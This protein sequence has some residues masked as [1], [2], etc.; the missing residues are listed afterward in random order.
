M[1]SK[2]VLYSVVYYSF[3]FILFAALACNN[4]KPPPATDIANTPQELEIK[5]TDIIES[6]LGYAAGHDGRIDDSIRLV[7]THLLQSIY[8]SNQY[9]T[10]WS[11]QERWKPIADSL[12]SFVG[13]AKLYGLF[14]EDYHYNLMDSVNRLFLADTSGKVAKRDAVLWAKIDMMM[15]DAFFHLVTDLKL[16][17]LPQDSV[18]QRKDSILSDEFYTAQFQSIYQGGSMTGVFQALEPSH[19]GYRLLKN[20]IKSFLDSADYK[21]YTK[22]PVRK[23]TVNFFPALHS[24]LAEGGFLS[25]DSIP[26]DS[27]K[28]ARAIKAFQQSKGIT[29]DG[30]IGDATIRMMNTS[31]RERFVRIAITLDRYKML[32]DSM[33]PRYVWINLPAFYMQ[34]IEADSTLFSSKI[35]CGK[36]I[37]R[38]PLL[39]SAIS[40]MVTYPQWTMPE[41]IITKE[42]LP[43]VKKDS[44]YFTKK[45][46]SLVNN[47][48]DE[49]DP[50]TVDWSKYKKG[51]PFNVVQ[52]SGDENALG[53]L[54]F[55][56]PNKYDVYLHDTNQRYLFARN[57]R[58]LSHGCVRVQEW[59]KLAYNIVRFDN[60]EKYPE[61]VS[62]TEDSLKVW[63]QKKEKHVIPVR[64][65]LPVFIRYFTCEAKDGKVV[66]Y[67]DIYGEDKALQEKFF[68]GK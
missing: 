40:N 27:V 24:R 12:R 19:T 33:P 23:D 15:T 67:D 62:P 57:M 44:A 3:I 37:T 55:N 56:F 52:G 60:Q 8:E 2:G 65:K 35:V 10:L 9:I 43:G 63:L 25:S 17:R 61:T 46:Y 42:V 22:V 6:A 38:T 59:E 29:A 21:I 34:L 7:N 1:S 31:D 45:G 36:D 41:S 51:I 66:F 49:V 20:S 11:S 5:A 54:K 50:H 39:T 58:S 32:P 47:K 14:P 68:A 64:K 16:G 13:D 26:V 48:G 18:T 53:I 4:A 28:L 30:K